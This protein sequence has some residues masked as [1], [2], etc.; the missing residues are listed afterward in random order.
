[1]TEEHGRPLR[2]LPAAD[3]M[4]AVDCD[5]ALELA[6]QRDVT[7]LSASRSRSVV[8]AKLSSSREAGQLQLA[9]VTSAVDET[10]AGARTTR[11]RL[12][13]ALST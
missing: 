7:R 10:A 1:M 6:T 5:P 11:S 8:G 13:R 4:K 2:R 3:P 9:T 12:V